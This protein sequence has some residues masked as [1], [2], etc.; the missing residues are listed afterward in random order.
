MPGPAR[1]PWG[2]AQS[3]RDGQRGHCSCA[4]R[5]RDRL[6]HH[7]AYRHC[8]GGWRRVFGSGTLSTSGADTSTATITIPAGSLA[9]GSDTLIITYNGDGTYAPTSTPEPVTVSPAT[10]VVTVSAPP[11]DNVA[12]AVLVDGDG[13]WAGGCAHAHWNGH[14]VGRHLQLVGYC[15]EQRLVTF[16]IPA[17]QLP[18]GTADTL[19]A[20][21]SGNSTYTSGTG[22]ATIS[23][24]STAQLTPTIKVTP[25]PTSIDTSQ[26]L[27]VSV[28]VSGTGATAPTGTVLLTRQTP[29]PPLRPRWRGHRKLH[30]P[31]RQFLG[32]DTNH[33]RSL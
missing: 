12:N 15:P 16:N 7:S 8:R 2:N 5:D 22:T 28:A 29:T 17:G 13:N 18:A 20:S 21:F 24:V 26:S 4:H 3:H 25:T 6:R 11:S 31:S 1:Q 27:T 30:R 19:T 33:H 14:S 10:P 9:V 32:R 23:M